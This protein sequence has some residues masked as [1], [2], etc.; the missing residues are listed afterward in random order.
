MTYAHIIYFFKKCVYVDLIF[1]E[2]LATKGNF[3]RSTIVSG[4]WLIFFI[5]ILYG[6][7]TRIVLWW[8]PKWVKELSILRTDIHM[9]SK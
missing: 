4:I 5:N 7:Q 2:F 1:L 9:F 3:Y 8:L 6:L